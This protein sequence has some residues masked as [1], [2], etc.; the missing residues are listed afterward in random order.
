ME[1][2]PSRPDTSSP[3]TVV[4]VRGRNRLEVRLAS[5]TVAPAG[6]ARYEASRRS[7]PCRWA[8]APRSSE[9]AG[10]T[11]EVLRTGLYGI[12]VEVIAAGCPLRKRG[13]DE[14][15]SSL[16]HLG[17]VVRPLVGL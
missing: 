8:W 12:C 17:Q 6:I 7:T 1:I 2:T 14:V 15:A 16:L 11:E 13:R 9:I 4:W 10:G 5:R 3:A